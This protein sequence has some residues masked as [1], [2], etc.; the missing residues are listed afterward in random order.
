MDGAVPHF[1]Y[2]INRINRS[3]EP[4]F[5]WGL[6]RFLRFSN[7][8]DFVWYPCSHI[9]YLAKALKEVNYL[10][11]FT[12]KLATM[13]APKLEMAPNA[14]ATLLTTKRSCRSLS[15]QST[16][17]LSWRYRKKITKKESA[18]QKLKRR[19]KTLLSGDLSAVSLM[20]GNQDVSL[21]L[22]DIR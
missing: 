17:C 18:A 11:L 13:Q 1:H 3:I 12:W 15:L 8:F 21:R 7:W 4:F 2:L 16:S 20:V 22:K 19:P 9:S 5:R 6:V 14:T 10:A